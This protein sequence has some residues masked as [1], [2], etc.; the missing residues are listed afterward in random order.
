[1]LALGNQTPSFLQETISSSIKSG[2]NHLNLLAD[3]SN[4]GIT[5]IILNTMRAI[6]NISMNNKNVSSAGS[7]LVHVIEGFVMSY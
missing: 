5:C 4:V 2:Y 7:K 6:F 1:L 3:N